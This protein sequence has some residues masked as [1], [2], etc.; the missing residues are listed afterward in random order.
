M[1]FRKKRAPSPAEIDRRLHSLR[2][3]DLFSGAS[4]DDLERL[5]HALREREVSAGTKVVREGRLP[6][7]V[8]VIMEGR[9]EV[10]SRGERGGK[11]RVV[12]VLGE[13]DHFG[14][15]GLIEGMPA[16]ATVSAQGSARIAEIPGE[17]FLS[18][19]DRSSSLTWVAD[20]ISTWL[21]RTHPSYR[22]SVEGGVAPEGT[23]GRVTELLR[24][25]EEAEVKE[26]EAGLRQL[27]TLD[28]ERRR[29]R[30]RD[31]GD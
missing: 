15:I 26:L 10:I 6:T 5:A 21:A 14:E 2:R 8:F 3:V 20:R 4:E 17:S 19:V 16:T 1:R 30:L 29:Q 11:P 23:L 9:F 28:P 25:W 22:P 24:R 12:N 7:H 18:F 27:E 13:G 31:L